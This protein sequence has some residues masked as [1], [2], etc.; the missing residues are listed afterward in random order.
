MKITLNELK[1]FVKK[2]LKEEAMGFKEISNFLDEWLEQHNDITK[3]EAL[4]NFEK[5]VN[6]A[7]KLI[8]ND[9]N[10]KKGKFTDENGNDRYSGNLY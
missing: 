3:E 7:I 1:S 2:V 5:T 9:I 4:N 8:R 6:Y 10:M